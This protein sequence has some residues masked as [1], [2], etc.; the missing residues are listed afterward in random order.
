MI[1]AGRFDLV[2]PGVN[3]TAFPLDPSRYDDRFLQ[4]IGFNAPLDIHAAS[5][6]IKECGLRQATPEQL[7]AYLASHPSFVQDAP[8]YTAIVAMGSVGTDLRKPPCLLRV[9]FRDDK[10]ILETRPFIGLL[11]IRERLLISHPD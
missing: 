10:R 2:H 9:R 3:P 8:D 6:K 7:L 4:L 5:A 11:E 1:A